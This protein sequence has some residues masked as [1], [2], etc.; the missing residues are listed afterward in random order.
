M[1]CYYIRLSFLLL[2]SAGL[3]LAACGQSER[4]TMRDVASQVRIKTQVVA[5]KSEMIHNQLNWPQVVDAVEDGTWVEADERI[6]LFDASQTSNQLERLLHRKQISDAQLKTSLTEQDNRMSELADKV[7]AA[8]DRLVVEEARLVALLAEPD[9]NALRVAEGRVRIT[10]LTGEAASNEWVRAKQRLE[11][12]LIS[13]AAFESYHSAYS[14]AQARDDHANEKWRLAARAA[15]PLKV[16][17]LHRVIDNLRVDLTN[18]VVQI[19]DTQKIVELQKQAA[20]IRA[21]GLDRQISDKEEE[22]TNVRVTAPKPGYVSYSRDFVRR[23]SSGTERMWRKYVF[24]RIPDPN[25]LVLRGSIKEAYR[26]FFNP[27]DPVE[28]RMIG[29]LNEPFMGHITAISEQARDQAE[30]EDAG[31]GGPN[32]Y[33]IKVYDVTIA[34][35]EQRPWMRLEMHAECEIRAANAIAAPAVPAEFLINRD[36]QRLLIVNGRLLPVSGTVVEGLFVLNDTNLVGTTISRRLPP[37]QEDGSDEKLSNI[38]FETAGELIPSDTT[39]VIIRDIYG[40]QKISW[41]IPENSAVT[42]GTVVVTID[43]KESRERLTEAEQRLQETISNR[44]A[45]EQSSI[46]AV[47]QNMAR[48]ATASNLV[49]IAEIDLALARQGADKTALA[50][51]CLQVALTAVTVADQKRTFDAVASRPPELT[52][53]KEQVRAKRAWEKAELEAE[54]ARLRL[55][56]VMS[57]PDVLELAKLKAALTEARLNIASALRQSETAAFASRSGLERNI[58]HEK[59]RRRYYERVQ[60]WVENLVVRAPRAGRVRYKRIWS[61]N[62]FSKVADGSMVASAFR[63]LMIADPVK[64]EIRAEVPERFYTAMSVGRRVLVQIPSVSDTFCD[65]T[66]TSVEYL[67]EEKK[68]KNV[69]RGIYSEHETLGETVFFMRVA[70]DPD[71]RVP[72]KAGA[73]ARIV[74]LRPEPAEETP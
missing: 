4:V 7:Q 22:L 24:A 14:R 35:D 2:W 66:V 61:N 33:G 27:G 34:P 59:R 70:V 8:R 73:A 72:L 47:R 12:N 23:Y 60:A 57:R 41:L 28:I 43:D 54:R 40:W 51:A 17:R 45:L 53:A 62:T 39:D 25:S 64:M 48:V 71:E 19:E 69:E 36:G 74:V 15:E 29:R 18:L 10:R 52:S 56:M 1:S 32:E 3:A 21:G 63:P 58:R 9:T 44:E 31:W 50:E 37:H 38:L 65:G 46:V 42:A 6:V 49:R 5:E 16:E 20:Q 13:P 55:N 30:R 26:R 11:A 68:P 67:F